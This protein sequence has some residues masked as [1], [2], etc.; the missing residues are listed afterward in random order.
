MP[1]GAVSLCGCVGVGG[2][3]PVVAGVAGGGCRSGVSGCRGRLGGDRHRCSWD[4]ATDGRFVVLASCL[5]ISKREVFVDVF[6]FVQATVVVLSAVLLWCGARDRLGNSFGWAA[7]R[8][9]TIRSV[10]A[11]VPVLAVAMVV[12]VGLRQ[13]PGFSWG[14]WRAVGG[15]GSP[16]LGAGSGTAEVPV[17]AQTVTLVL[18]MLLLA[19]VPAFAHFEESMFRSGA[20]SRSGRENGWSALLFGAAHAVCGVSFALCGALVVLGLW[21]NHV[22]M[23]TYRQ[24]VVTVSAARPGTGSGAVPAGDAAVVADSSVRLCDEAAAAALAAATAAHITWNWL[25]AGPLAVLLVVDVFA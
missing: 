18:V 3:W 23:R 13:L 4:V 15:T 24:H 17:L 8:R 6:T 21:L 1:A 19:A 16:L 10:V 2:V 12:S 7:V 11:T 9:I 20:E 14:W 22:Y 5:V 25:I